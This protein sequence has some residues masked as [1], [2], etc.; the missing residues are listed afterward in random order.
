MIFVFVVQ[1]SWLHA[2]FMSQHVGSSGF[3]AQAAP[4][5]LIVSGFA[6]AMC[7]A[8]VHVS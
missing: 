8:A 1:E 3:V 4:A 5:H 6:L 7:V 2:S